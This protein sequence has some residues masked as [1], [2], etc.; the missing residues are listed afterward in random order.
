MDE[1]V[2]KAIFDD[3]EILQALDN[4]ERKLGSVGNEAE[5]FKR[6][7]ADAFSKVKASAKDAGSALGSDFGVGFGQ[8]LSDALQD[9]Q[10][11]YND[12]KRS[13]DTLKAALKTAT[14]PTAIKL[15]AKG[16]AE[17]E[18]GMK[19]LEKAGKEAGV[20]LKEA[21]KSA[22]TGREVFEGLFGAISKATIILAV[23]EGVRKL[24]AYAV[25]LSQDIKKAT[26]SFEAFTGSAESAKSIVDS[27][28]ATADR[29]FLDIDNTLKAGKALLAFG[30]AAGDIPDVLDRIANVSAATGKD[31]NELVTIYG[32]ARTAGVLYAEDINQLVD[33]G[34]PIIQEFAKQMGVSNSEV[35]KLASEGKISFEELQLAMFNLTKEGEKFSGQ[36]KVQAD[37]L[38][39]AWAAAVASVRPGLQA[40]GDLVSDFLQGAL[41]GFTLVNNAIVNLFGGGNTQSIEV[42]YSGRDAYEQAKDDIY[43]L[44]RL[45]KAAADARKLA[46]QKAG[47][48]AAKAAR[49]RQQVLISGMKDGIEK[50]IAIENF[51]FSELSKNLRKYRLST[52]DAE[53]QHQKNLI[54]IQYNAAVKIAADLEKLNDLRIQRDNYEKEV[55]EKNLKARIENAEVTKA[56]NLG[57][58]DVSEERFNAFI[59]TLE[60]EGVAEKVINEKRFELDQSIKKQRLEAELAFQETLL[61]LTDAGDTNRLAQ[62]QNSIDLI[63]AKIE[64]L[65]TETPGQGRGGKPFSIWTLLGVEDDEQR[66]NYE[67]SV[68]LIIDGL[69]QIAEA[70]VREAEAATQAAE[71]KVQA[72]EDAL[73]KEKDI[74]KD[75]HANNVSLRQLELADAKKARDQALKDEAKARRAQIL[76]DTAVQGSSLITAAANI[77]KG[78]STIPVLGQ[79]LAVVSVAAMF[80]SFAA[81]K[82]QALKAAQVPKLRRGAKIEG[83]THEQGGEL[84]E[85]EH[86][87]Q[88]V[89]APESAGQDLF[90]ER[91]RK[92]AYNGL[93]LA[94][95]ADG[96]S[97]N[98]RNPLGEA[99]PRIKDLE[100]RRASADE[101]ARFNALAAAYERVGDKITSAI[102]AKPD[103][104]PWKGG[105]KER[106]KSGNVTTTKVVQPTD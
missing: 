65:G 102:M 59:N 46:A 35:K 89:G 3:Q 79:V 39:G 72:A 85:L 52:R 41:E 37:S 86:N 23:I 73:E 42:D 68:A 31:F 104:Y 29:N 62:V 50:E 63:R 13:S 47:A 12:L 57:L 9:L 61:S 27:L 93:D 98:R 71:E 30:E 48:E 105:Y 106:R 69:N 75:G 99:A 53:E 33:A 34:I 82:A 77:F 95:I 10:K 78:F 15:Y 14:D 26:A 45:E 49:D 60:K 55:S 20:S 81:A 74:A 101:A 88:V 54:E 25:G 44:Q 83:R 8:G 21:S 51:R 56:I 100:Q 76:L 70:R 11:E 91:M 24:T 18:A 28:V 67:K 1:N 2:F 4:V 38:S 103:I 17:L 6:E 7:M 32:K 19:K 94:A 22:N 84:R 58:I 90:F 66:K 97:D 40:I 64:T 96:R 92:G 5:N 16:V 80:A 43:E 87:E 36:A